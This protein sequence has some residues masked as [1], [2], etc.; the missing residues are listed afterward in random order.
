MGKKKLLFGVGVK[1]EHLI[2]TVFVSVLV[3]YV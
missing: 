2:T 3:T 1:D